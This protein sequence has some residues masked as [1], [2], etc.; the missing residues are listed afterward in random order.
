M[1]AMIDVMADTVDRQD[2]V[3]RN[4]MADMSH[5]LRTPVAV[6][7]AGHEAILD[8]LVEP[9]NDTV[10]HLR[11]EALRIAAMA[12]ELGELAA[13]QAAVRIAHPQPCDAAVL[14]GEV[15]DVE[16]VCVKRL[17]ERAA[18]PVFDCAARWPT[19]SRSL[20]GRRGSRSPGT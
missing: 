17:A 9:T 14:C 15:A 11:D 3:S 1:G 18:L 8:G 5:D 20:A 16:V 7:V 4:L 12:D 6:L 2:T 10:A 19:N 13:V